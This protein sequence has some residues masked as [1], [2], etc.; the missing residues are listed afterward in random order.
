MSETI[1]LIPSLFR[2]L[3]LA[4][5]LHS[6]SGCTIIDQIQVLNPFT[7]TDLTGDDWSSQRARIDALKHWNISGKIGIKTPDDTSSGFIDWHQQNQ[8]YQIKISGALGLGATY[9][10]GKPPYVSVKSAGKE[11]FTTTNPDELL[12]EQIGFAM[13]LTELQHWVKGL[14]APGSDFKMTYYPD[15]TPNTMKQNDW[16]L[17]FSKFKNHQPENILLPGKIVVSGQG[18]RITLIAKTWKTNPKL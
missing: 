7:E 11:E 15:G 5:V 16:D 18:Y 4:V 2:F 8:A 6:F 3:A 13:P 12:K 1:R 10:D 14:P 9:I 17:T